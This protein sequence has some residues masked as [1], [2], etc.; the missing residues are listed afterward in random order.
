MLSDAI[1]QDCSGNGFCLPQRYFAE[2]AGRVYSAP[3]DA[4]KAIGC[5]CDAGYRGSDCSLQECPSTADP[6]E[7]LTGLLSG[8]CVGIISDRVWQ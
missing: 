5:Q 4:M 1:S 8:I 2:N 7:G 3:W 6:L